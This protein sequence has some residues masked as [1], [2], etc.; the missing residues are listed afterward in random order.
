VREGEKKRLPR[1]TL[2]KLNGT[3][4]LKGKKA[5]KLDVWFQHTSAASLCEGTEILL[6][7]AFENDRRGS[8]ESS[9]AKDAPQKEKLT[10]IC[11]VKLGRDGGASAESD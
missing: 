9:F 5:R 1:K 11:V 7:G 10:T 6:V 3:W 2:S 8:G 4:T